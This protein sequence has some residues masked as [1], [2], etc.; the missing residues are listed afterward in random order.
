MD[1]RLLHSC[2]VVHPAGRPAA[3]AGP[4]PEG[5]FEDTAAGSHYMHRCLALQAHLQQ[6]QAH[7]SAVLAARCPSAAVTWSDIVHSAPTQV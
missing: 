3:A 1:Q 4:R 7:S 2:L 6:Q 5:G